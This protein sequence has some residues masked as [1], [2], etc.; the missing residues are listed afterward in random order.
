VLERGY[1]I[2][3]ADNGNVVTDSRQL[4]VADTLR[5]QFARGGAQVR[6]HALLPGGSAGDTDA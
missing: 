2:V 5:V 3:V 6:V 4:H 1:A